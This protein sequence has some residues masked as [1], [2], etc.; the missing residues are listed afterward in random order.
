MFAA[1][2]C[3]RAPARARRSCL[4][5][6]LWTALATPLAAE[7]EP[8]FRAQTI[9]DRVQIGYGVAIG[10][11]DGDGKPDILLADKKQFVWYQNPGWQR[12]VMV[13]NLTV[14]DNVCIAARDIDGDGK[15][16]IA[17]GAQWNPSDTVNSGSVHYLVP[18]DDRREPWKPIQLPHEPTV[19]RMRWVKVGPRKFVLV[20]APLHG[21]GNRNGQGEG[22]RL[23]AY[24]P[25][26]D[27]EMTWKTTVLE[28]SLHMTH[29]FDPAQWDPATEAEEILYIGREGALLIAHDG[30][31]W[32]RRKF[33][34]VGGGGEIRMGLL[35]S[36]QPFVVTVEA[37]HGDQ[38]ICYPASGPR[39]G[40]GD[41]TQLAD[42]VLLDDN[43]SGGH[44]IATADLLGSSTQQIV[45]G[46]RLP[47]R[48][49]QV[50]IKLYV[51]Q[52]PR[53]TQWKAHWIDENGM[54]TEDLRIGDL[55]GDGRPDIVA[56]GRATHN[57]K[58]YWNETGPAR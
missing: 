10:D 35:S 36:T 54:A 24:H 28:D 27:P 55:N 57:L 6:L 41:P 46:W 23:L 7:V 31:D 26:A 48:D 19:H 56:A 25:P 53:G 47:N 1:P 42:R 45:A 49:G 52:N 40:Q 5:L 22:V 3:R 4:S 32:S 33:E 34:R 29:N 15:V 50:G 43:Y 20:V 18:P 58:I 13:E 12:H 8:R 11:V 30:R 37:M 16:E 44:A 17:V 21:R 9:D 2:L 38:L 14:H 39:G 51:P